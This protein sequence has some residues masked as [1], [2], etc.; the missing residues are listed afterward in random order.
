[1]LM[2]RIVMLITS[3]LLALS[4]QGCVGT[5]MSGEYA[6]SPVS[7]RNHDV[8][9]SEGIRLAT[10]GVFDTSL[11]LNG[12]P[13]AD[14]T[15]SN[16]M[17][18]SSMDLVG[19]VIA[20]S[21]SVGST[22]TPLVPWRQ[23]YSLGGAKDVFLDND[24]SGSEALSTIQG[25]RG[26]A[27]LVQPVVG[28]KDFSAAFAF[29]ATNEQTGFGFDLNLVPS[30]SY[31]EEGEFETRRVGAEIR[32]GWDFDQRG[33]LAVADSWYIFA[34][35]DN[36]ALVWEAGEYGLSD[37]TSAMALRDQVTVGDLQAGVSVQRGNGQLSF[38]YIRR[39]V[40]WGDRTGSVTENEDFA[41]VSFTLKH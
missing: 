17:L 18:G 5:V 35:T 26:A 24:W 30:V 25:S 3:S 7:T 9:V 15:R 34:G 23:V 1:M 29:G 2:G 13:Q 27:R 38:S 6:A 37:V 19:P 41:G 31:R 10:E 28:K 11:N 39:E 21:V 32:L 20:T 22:E 8:V 14:A 16:L 4:C 12:M 40:H 36:E 33:D